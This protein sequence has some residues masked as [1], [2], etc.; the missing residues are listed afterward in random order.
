MLE[1]STDAVLSLRLYMVF[2]TVLVSKW[3]FRM[4]ISHFGSK[5]TLMTSFNVN[6]LFKDS[7]FQ[8]QPLSAALEG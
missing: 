4:T 8:T 1:G 6:C 3:P 5:L 2:P 7:C